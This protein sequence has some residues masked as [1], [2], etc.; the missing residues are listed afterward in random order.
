MVYLPLWC[1]LD[2]IMGKAEKTRSYII[3]KTAPIFNIKGFAG[4]SM[5]DITEATGLTKGSIY[6]NFKNKDEVAL[7]VFE[8][9]K[10]K[11]QDLFAMEIGKK[12]S[13]RDKLLAYPEL[14]EQFF[15][16][17]FIDGGCPIMNT[18]IEAD[19]TH[20]LL[21]E[22]SKKALL[23][24]KDSLT[25]LVQKGIDNKEFKPDTN[26]EDTALQML[27]IIEGTVMISKLTGR[28]NYLKTLMLSLRK[29]IN[30]L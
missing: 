21:K 14:Y 9:N 11:I 1:Y 18:A 22:A 7:E 30:E 6:G 27:A 23:L 16:G 10:K 24:W 5:N 15:N 26:P 13:Y 29:L 28:I 4:T 25:T 12:K 2:I 19:D 20:P 3:E 17:H 8:H